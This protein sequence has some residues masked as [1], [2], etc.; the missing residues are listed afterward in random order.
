MGPR[1]LI[2]TFFE[3]KTGEKACAACGADLL[4]NTS[5]LIRARSVAVAATQC[6]YMARLGE[7]MGV[8][9]FQDS[10]IPG[11]GQQVH[12]ICRWRFQSY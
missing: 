6:V 9:G 12:M 10:V 2:E 7:A 5:H 1:L 4:N 11:K 3:Q 8:R